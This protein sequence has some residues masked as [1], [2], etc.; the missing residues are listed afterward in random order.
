MQQP[1]AGEATP[2]QAWSKLAEDSRATLIDVRTP[3]EWSFVGV[4][5]LSS[6][7]KE[8][9]LVP[10]ALYPSMEVNASFAQHIAALGLRKDAPLFFM[11]R[12]GARSRAAAIAMTK[13]GYT[14]CYNVTTGFEGDKN[15]AGHRGQFAGW[16]ADGLPWQQG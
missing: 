6:I 15:E 5:D 7:G 14:A 2:Q 3:A 8:P 11:C 16:K 13:Q 12:S 9:V 4:A 1:Y 10:W